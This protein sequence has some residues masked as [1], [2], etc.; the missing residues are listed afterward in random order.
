MPFYIRFKEQYS[1][2]NNDIFFIMDFSKEMNRQHTCILELLKHPRAVLTHSA[3][4]QKV[5]PGEKRPRGRP[6]KWVWSNR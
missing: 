4:P 6:R 1:L 3:P 2:E 5:E